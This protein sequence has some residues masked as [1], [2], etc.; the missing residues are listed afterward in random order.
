[1]S[2]RRA[3]FDQSAGDDWGGKGHDVASTFDGCSG[4]VGAASHP[5]AARLDVDDAKDTTVALDWSAQCT[6]RPRAKSP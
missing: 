5:G 2:I 1:M 3:S 4:M 6:P